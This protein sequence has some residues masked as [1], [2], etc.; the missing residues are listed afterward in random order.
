MNIKLLIPGL[1]ALILVSGTYIVGSYVTA[2]QQLAA[3]SASGA[4]HS[5]SGTNS[6]PAAGNGGANTNAKGNPQVPQAAGQKKAFHVDT[7]GAL[8]K[9]DDQ[10]VAVW[11]VKP[12]HKFTTLP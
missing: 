10:S 12:K 1:A 6:K 5:N 3:A 9:L 11:L 2:Q 8:P 7:S 4:A